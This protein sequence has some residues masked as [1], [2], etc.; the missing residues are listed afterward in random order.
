LCALEDGLALALLV[1]V[2]DYTPYQKSYH[3]ADHGSCDYVH[4]NAPVHFS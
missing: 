1:L 4:G 3:D 2:L